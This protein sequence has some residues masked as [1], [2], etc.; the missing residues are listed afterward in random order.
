MKRRLC[1]VFFLVVVL[2]VTACAPTKSWKSEPSMKTASN[3]F[4]D[5]S[6]TPVYRFNG[7][8]GFVLNI[9]N[10]ITQNIEIDWNNTFYIHLG[11]KD[12]GFWFEG[13]KDG[14]KK[15]LE[16]TTIAAGEMFYKE[17]YP[18]KLRV[19][20]QMAA[21]YVNENMGTGENGIYLT[22]NVQGKNVFETMTIVFS[23]E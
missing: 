8:K 23:E 17:I 18:A 7:Y 11:N 19:L 2:L 6:I 12:G 16:S 20:S 21:A 13:M 5:A 14:N 1:L 10:K 3:D 4:F 9:H 15:T 22:I